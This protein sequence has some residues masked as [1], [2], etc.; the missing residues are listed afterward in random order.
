MAER[1]GRP[2]A[3]RVAAAVLAAGLAAAGSVRAQGEGDALPA[4]VGPAARTGPGTL[5]PDAILPGVDPSA[6]M[7]VAR[8][9]ALQER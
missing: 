1:A 4:E 2:T 7:G 6:P 9:R 5:R 3:R 8:A